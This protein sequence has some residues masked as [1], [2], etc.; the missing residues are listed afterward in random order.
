MSAT[1]ISTRR[2]AQ[3]PQC[4]ACST[5]SLVSFNW[6]LAKTSSLADARQ[7]LSVFVHPETLRWGTLFQ[8][9]R[10]AQPWYLDGDERFMNCVLRDRVPLIREWNRQSIPLSPEQLAALERIGRTPPDR[11]GN[12]AEF[13]ETPCSVVTRSGTRIDRAIVSQQ[14]H[15]PFEDSR[16]YRLASEIESIYPSPDALSLKVRT[17]AG[18]AEEYR[19]GFAPTLVEMPAG[20]LIV[21]N[22]REN[23]LV[24]PGCNAGDVVL[25]K[26]SIDMNHL[27]EIYSEPT[28]TVYFVADYVAPPKL[29]LLRKLF[30]G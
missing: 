29:G 25:S 13:H 15:A 3:E 5:G 9:V 28:D 20:E 24:R 19:M 12:G 7:D 14:R 10:C 4:S 1:R 8:C 30:G 22:G 17:A 18:E 27:P 6:N 26:R 16:S 23:F 2:I 11:Y 21:L